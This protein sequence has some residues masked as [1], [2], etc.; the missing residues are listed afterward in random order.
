MIDAFASAEKAERYG[1]GAALVALGEPAV[2][3]LMALF[4]KRGEPE[5]LRLAALGLLARMGSE[6]REIAPRFEKYLKAENSQVRVRAAMILLR[7]NPKA[8]GIGLLLDT[9]E[10]KDDEN[11]GDPPAYEIYAALGRLVS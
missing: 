3:P 2:G 6:T 8:G 4:E 5:E 10:K 7:H 9:L 1:P 11:H